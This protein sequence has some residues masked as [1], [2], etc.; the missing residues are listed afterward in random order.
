MGGSYCLGSQ[1]QMKYVLVIIRT[2]E[3]VEFFKSKEIGIDEKE[4]L[5]FFP[6]HSDPDPNPLVLRIVDGRI[7]GFESKAYYERQQKEGERLEYGWVEANEYIFYRW[8]V[9][10]NKNN[11]TTI[12][13]KLNS[14]MKRLLDADTKKL[15]KAG[16]IDGDL[17]LT[18][19]GKLTMWS[20]L[21]EA[22]KAA[23][24]AA[25]DELIAEAKENN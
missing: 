15:I 5:N 24:L 22:N 14:M 2:K 25:A 4:M 18:N 16:L 21:V 10:L 13:S 7:D 11:Q 8:G 20:I 6:K 19:E 3:Q 1:S 9:R 12:M 17:L 23:L